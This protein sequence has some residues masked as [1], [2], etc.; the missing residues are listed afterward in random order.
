MEMTLQQSI[1]IA[2]LAKAKGYVVRAKQGKVQFVVGKYDAKGVF[3][4]ELEVT[5]W[6][7]YDEALELIE[8]E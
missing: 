1:Q 5:D 3:Q 8:T 6:I 7:G 4:V 2:Q